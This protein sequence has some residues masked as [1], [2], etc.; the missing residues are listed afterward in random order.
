MNYSVGDRVRIVDETFVTCGQ[1]GTVTSLYG[2]HS[3]FSYDLVVLVDG[4]RHPAAFLT[5]E[6]EPA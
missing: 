2:P 1:E 6:I 3:L 4:Q 5:R